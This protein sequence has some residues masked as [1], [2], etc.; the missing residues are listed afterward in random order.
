[1]LLKGSC[2]CGCVTFNVTSKH[3]YPFNY[4]YCSICRKTQGGGGSVVNLSGD[5]DSLRVE[6]EDNLSVY[7]A[8]IYSEETHRDEISPARRHFCKICSSNL[9]LWDPRWPELIHP[10]ASAIDTPLPSAPQRTHLMV[11]SK[12]EWVSMHKAGD[13]REYGGYPEE[14]IEA[15]HKRLDLES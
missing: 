11:A 2:H 15:W 9:W 3:P 7:Q 13:D 5:V 10:F 1:M 12:P 6:G 4:C 14:S 8:R